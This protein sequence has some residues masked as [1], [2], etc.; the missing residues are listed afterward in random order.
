MLVRDVE[1]IEFRMRSYNM[2]GVRRGGVC[3][4]DRPLDLSIPVRDVWM[5]EFV[6]C[7]SYKRCFDGEVC[8]CVIDCVIF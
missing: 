4:C 8:V 3:V 6:M 5:N 7:A 2:N 1:M